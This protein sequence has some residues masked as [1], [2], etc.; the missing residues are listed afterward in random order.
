MIAHHKL[1]TDTHQTTVPIPIT[2]PAIIG[3]TVSIDISIS[4]VAA[5]VIISKVVASCTSCVDGGAGA[6]NSGVGAVVGRGR[7][8]IFYDIKNGFVE[9]STAVILIRITIPDL[10]LQTTI[11]KDLIDIT[12]RGHYS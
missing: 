1:S 5:E 6:P 8:S 11:R 12:E 4:V 9:K 7:I 3:N 10:L 2:K